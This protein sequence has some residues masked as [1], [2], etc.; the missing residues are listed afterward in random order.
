NGRYA[1][2]PD[3]RAASFPAAWQYP[4]GRA[5]VS[6]K[7]AMV[8]SDAPLASQAGVEILRRG[9]NAVDAAVALAFAMAVVYPEAGNLGGGGYMVIH[10][11]KGRAAAIDFRE[12]APLAA[13]RDMYVGTDGKVTD[14]SLVGP[15]ASGVPGAVAGLTEALAKY[16]TMKLATV[17]APA[18]RLASDGFVVDSALASSLASNA[19]LLERFAGA[20]LFLPA[21][22]APVA[23]TLL[24]QPALAA[25]LRAIAAKGRA[26]FYEGPIAEAWTRELQSAGGIIT[27]EDLRRY[28]PAWR[29]PIRSTY[30]G[31]TMLAMPPSSS[32]GVTMTESLNILEGYK[33][34]PEFGSVRW[35][36][37][38]GSA[39]Q[40]A[41][42][43][44]NALLGDPAFVSVPIKRLT[45]K[46]YAARLRATIGADRATPTL[47]IAAAAPREGMETT[48]MA[49]ADAR[50]N[51][52]AMTTTLNNLYGSG[53]Y[54]TSGGFFLN[55]E[56]D[57]FSVQPGT[58]NM[59][60]LVQG[61]SN[62]IQPGKRMLSAMSPTIVLDARGKVLLVAGSRGGPRI[63]TSTTE[64]VMNVLDYRMTLA[65]AMSAPRLH[66]QALPDTLRFERNGITPATADS[67]RLMGYNVMVGQSVGRVNALM[68]V[69]G[70]FEGVSDPRGSGRAIGY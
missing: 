27:P 64:V 62:A 40:R 70:G 5:P 48:H 49:V 46:G 9:G 4:A 14:G 1:V 60:G 38:L 51:A 66:H 17:M 33:S 19:P 7:H 29:E 3:R 31:Y 69:K 11:A 21:G 41:F 53:V 15:L 50:G 61:E 63:I 35:A 67:L 18:I 24:R 34:L 20:T 42:I 55:D 25:T 45:D 39:F 6:A 58:P 22:K 13:T 65:D 28:R 36:H 56:M 10:R 23:G 59:F 30:R 12:V 52:V 57:D 16:G 43:D 47:S 8:V 2:A 32:G 68:R 26:G 37:L 54:V 44:R